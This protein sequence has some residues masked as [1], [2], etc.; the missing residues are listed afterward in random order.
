MAL[1]NDVF[2]SYASDTKPLAEQLAETL[3]DEGIDTWADFKDLKPGQLIRDEV[4]GALNRADSFVIIVG[5]HSTA[6][7]WAELEWQLALRKAW[8]DPGK[9]LIPVVVGENEPP[10]FLRDWVALRVNPSDSSEWTSQVLQL[11]RAAP[12]RVQHGFSSVELETRHKRLGE[13]A[14]AAEELRKYEIPL[15]AEMESHN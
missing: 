6:S 10:P 9:R 2:I 15:R 1:Q 4:E 3:R 7:R 8:S 5:P 14:L 13:I 11:L 12:T